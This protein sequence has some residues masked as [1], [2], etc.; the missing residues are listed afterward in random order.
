MGK[1]SCIKSYTPNLTYSLMCR[2]RKNYTYCGDPDFRISLKRRFYEFYVLN[3]NYVSK[4]PPVSTMQR[5]QRLEV[6]PLS[7]FF[8]KSVKLLPI[9]I[10]VRL[11]TYCLFGMVERKCISR[12]FTVFKFLLKFKDA[13][14]NEYKYFFIQLAFVFVFFVL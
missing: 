12:C 1:C 8:A 3:A 4:T 11:C 14:E 9:K 13:Y 2:F 10:L 5:C 6:Y 7:I